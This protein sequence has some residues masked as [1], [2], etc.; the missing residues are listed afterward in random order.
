MIST[1]KQQSKLRPVSTLSETI[2][3]KSSLVLY[4]S[5]AWLLAASLPAVAAD[6]V[7]DLTA[8]GIDKIAPCKT[9]PTESMFP[10]ANKPQPK[11]KLNPGDALFIKLSKKEGRSDYGPCHL[12]SRVLTEQ[13]KVLMSLDKCSYLAISAGEEKVIIFATGPGLG[14]IEAAMEIPIE[15]ASLS[16]QQEET[17]LN[18]LPAVTDKQKLCASTE[19]I[20]QI[21]SEINDIVFHPYRPAEEHRGK[22]MHPYLFAL[23]SRSGKACL[24]YL[25]SLLKQDD[26]V[27]NEAI[28]CMKMLTN[29][30]YAISPEHSTQTWEAWWQS[31]AADYG[32]PSKQ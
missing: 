4:M 22:L 2:M 21:Q 10:M 15:V 11:V 25:A 3:P 17:L 30:D 13:S 6:H 8:Y 24:P 16:S 29:S 31:H 19:E 9:K 27:K 7:V 1:G 14:I 23:A 28:I 26:E 20:R 5:I 32:V 18:T 12:D